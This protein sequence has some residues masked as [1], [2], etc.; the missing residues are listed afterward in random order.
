M[1]IFDLAKI[2]EEVH[3]EKYAEFNESPHIKPSENFNYKMQM[4]LNEVFTEKEP[5][6]AHN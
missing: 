4:L 3:D 5:N 1:P 6:K 2:L